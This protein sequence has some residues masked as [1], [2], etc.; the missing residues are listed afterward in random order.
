[1]IVSIFTIF[2]AEK[3]CGC[4]CA[5]AGYYHEFIAQWNHNDTPVNTGH[6][7]CPCLL[8]SSMGT[9]AWNFWRHRQLPTS[10]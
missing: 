6:N 8:L 10:S 5:C 3:V 7:Y 2:K 9:G 1:M 4:V